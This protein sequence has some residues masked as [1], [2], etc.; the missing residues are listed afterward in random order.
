MQRAA[1]PHFADEHPAAVRYSRE[2]LDALVEPG[3]I[4]S[5]LFTSP[6][7]FELEMERIFHGSW[8]YIGHEDEL[9]QPGDY[10][11]R[12]MG[13]QPVIF[14][15]SSQGK[16]DVFLNRC[17]HR[18]AVVAEQECGNARHFKCWWHGWIYDNA[19]RLVD[20]PRDD[21]YEGD[22]KQRI[23]GLTRPARVGSYRGFVFASLAA[24][25]PDLDAHL[26]A[27]AGMLDYLVDASPDGRLLMDA[28]ENRT[29]YEANWK[30]VGMDGYHVETVHAS[31]LTI[32]K[33]RASEGVGATHRGN[34]TGDKALVRTRDYGNGHVA[35]D[36]RAHRESHAQ[37]YFD[38][39]AGIEGGAEYMASLRAKHGEER[40][41]ALILAAGD[42]HIGIYPNMQIVT[43]HIRIINPISADRTQIVMIPVKL[44]GAP[45]AVNAARLRV[46]ES[47]YG[48]ASAGSPDDAEVFERAQRGLMATADPW[49]EISRGM[50]REKVEA[51][52]TIS[53]L[54]ADEVP[55]RG[56]AR[57]WLRLM[58]RERA[59]A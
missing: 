1:L 7:L 56:Q 26:G 17:R 31:V 29:S 5:A 50:S 15:R 58:T 59:A 13:R 40:G 28:G 36:Y 14:V 41:T 39:L 37:D 32:I 22:V 12:T 30:F 57:E 48:P 43:N 33:Q 23:G 25:V 8:L 27:A 53:G 47:F 6:G 19:G 46:H 4:H 34:A 3:R 11:L 24:D 42:P 45:A 35:L 18:G 16:V 2:Q 55:Q 52:G 9:P 20:V 51:D 38:Y 49:I 21:A 44:G 10:K 54:I